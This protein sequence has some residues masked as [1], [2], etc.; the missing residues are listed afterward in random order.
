MKKKMSTEA[1][2]PNLLRFIEK[3]GHY[4]EGMGIPKIGGRIM[5]LMLVQE[6]PLSSEDIA[7]ILKVS[8]GS[9]S[10]NIR[11]LLVSGLVEK[12][13]VAG[14]RKE[15]YEF[16]KNAWEKAV[17]FKLANLDPLKEI[18]TEGISIVKKNKTQHKNLDDMI[19]VINLEKKYAEMFLQ[20]WK[21]I[22][23][24]V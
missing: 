10:T 5:G 17:S 12:V 14:D 2:N 4:Y 24:K 6:R 9:V 19:S 7:K 15:F 13:S 20:E 11:M 18:V 21:S 16:S 22:R 3:M 8:R 23:S 1:I